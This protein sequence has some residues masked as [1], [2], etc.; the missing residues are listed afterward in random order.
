MFCSAD[1]S[2]WV[3]LNVCLLK[4]PREKFQGYVYLNDWDSA[5]GLQPDAVNVKS[6]ANGCGPSPA[7]YTPAL[8]AS[9]LYLWGPS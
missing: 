1:D 8:D 2:M 5:L 9:G 7:P 3:C 4:L 6:G